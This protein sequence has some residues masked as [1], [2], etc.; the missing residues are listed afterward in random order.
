MKNMLQ[1]SFFLHSLPNLLN[2]SKLYREDELLPIKVLTR[3]FENL[4][5]SLQSLYINIVAKVFLDVRSIFPLDRGATS[6]SEHNLYH[7][8]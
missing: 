5:I 2:I 4:S 8:S 6:E 1:R 3:K 7:M